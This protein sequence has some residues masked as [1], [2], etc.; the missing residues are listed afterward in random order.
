MADALETGATVQRQVHALFR[1]AER[2]SEILL[3]YMR[4]AAFIILLML[5]KVLDFP[6]PHYSHVVSEI[7]YGTATAAWLVL[8]WLRYH[9]PWIA[10]LMTSL[11]IALVLHFYAMLVLYG[12]VSAAAALGVPGTL[13]VF[14]F[15]AHTAARYRPELVVYGTA[16]FIAGWAGI[17]AAAESGLRLH[18]G[19]SRDSTE[20]AF[21]MILGLTAV[22]LFVTAR[23]VRLL[24]VEAISEAHLRATLSR[25]V[26]P[27]L[28]QELSQ[29]ERAALR[30]P[31]LQKVAILFID[32][33]GFTG[34]AER[35]SPEQVVEFLGEYRRRVSAA[36]LDHDG[37]VDKF[38]GD[39][40][41]AVFGVPVPN[42][43]DAT[44][45]ACSGL[46]VLKSI[47]S[48]NTER[49]L[50]GLP[51]ISVGIGGHYGDVIVGAIG[52]ETRLEY[53]VVGDA[54]NV[55]QRLERICAETGEG[56]VISSEML[57]SVEKR[58][59]LGQWKKLAVHSVRGRMQ[60]VHLFALAH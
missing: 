12:G 37:T 26:P 35:M 23:R 48:W 50:Q 30:P 3:G 7:V 28:A 54:V 2:R 38:I 41:M 19:D 52:D 11:D 25:F 57:E 18:W 55:A 17:H 24:L 1:E 8:A 33:R 49:R 16:V 4:V 10:W 9:R 44:N 40:V 43:L 21:L 32:V 59:R 45:A 47:E 39:G 58:Y 56:F 46:S 60:P 29:P 36:I 31:R 53:T 22:A 14:L 13:I 20:L 42:S 51:E 34:I 15:L 5:L 27:V 6:G